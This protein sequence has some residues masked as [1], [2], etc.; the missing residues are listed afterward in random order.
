MDAV[1]VLSA[2]KIAFQESNVNLRSA[3]FEFSFC[4]GLKLKRVFVWNKFALHIKSKREH[5]KRIFLT[6]SQIFGYKGYL[7]NIDLGSGDLFKYIRVL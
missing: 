3:R 6:L 5:Q 4:I 1:V 7:K 2:W